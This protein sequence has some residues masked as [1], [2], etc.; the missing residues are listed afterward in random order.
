MNRRRTVIGLLLLCTLAFTALSAPSAQ[1]G[2]TVF[3]CVKDA[4][5]KEFKNEHC[6][7]PGNDG[8]SYGHVEIGLNKATEV[9]ANNEKTGNET[10]ETTNTVL[11]GVVAGVKTEIVCSKVKGFDTVENKTIELPDKEKTKVMV[12]IGTVKTEYNSC[13]VAKPLNCTVKQPIETNAAM[14]SFA[15]GEEMGFEFTP[16]EGKA[17]TEVTFEGGK[18]VLT[19]APIPVKGSV[20]ASVVGA[21]VT[22]EGK[23]SL[24]FGGGPATLTGAETLRMAGGGNPIS[25]TTFAP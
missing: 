9:E 24:T 17:L 6:G 1:A 22:F 25:T 18:C 20:K 13:T 15:N 19:G 16:P 11:A 21:T 4:G 2:T 10:K 8:K 7:G 5:A 14:E 23:G 12:V 3:T